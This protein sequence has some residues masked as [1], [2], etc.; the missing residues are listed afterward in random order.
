M[1]ELQIWVKKAWPPPKLSNSETI[2]IEIMYWSTKIGHPE[3]S[4]I[5]PPLA[6]LREGIYRKALLCGMPFNAWKM[7]MH[8][9]SEKNL[10]FGRGSMFCTAATESAAFSYRAEDQ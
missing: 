4:H 5:A 3:Q 8:G 2:A 9:N 10:L 1:C 7:L 6:A